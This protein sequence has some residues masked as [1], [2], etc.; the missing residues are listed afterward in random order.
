MLRNIWSSK[1]T[2]WRLQKEDK[3][4]K[5]KLL[6]M[7]QSLLFILVCAGPLLAQFPGAPKPGPELD[8]GSVGSAITLLAG[9][10]M[11]LRDRMRRK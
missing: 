5:R 10:L 4:M 6:R 3:L 1:V 7:G 8:P 11:I 9:G 2:V